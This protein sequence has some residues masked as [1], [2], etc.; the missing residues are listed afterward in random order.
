M[1]ERRLHTYTVVFID[2]VCPKFIDSENN[3]RI[4]PVE[5]P[6]VSGYII[7]TCINVELRNVPSDKGVYIKM[8]KH[9]NE[10]IDVAML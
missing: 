5:V 1:C 8:L 7:T 6:S 4:I 9:D 2:L 10:P 3:S